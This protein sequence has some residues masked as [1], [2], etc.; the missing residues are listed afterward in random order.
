MDTKKKIEILTQVFKQAAAAAIA[1]DPGTGLE[2][3]GG[4]CN[5]DSPAFRIPGLRQNTIEAA[6]EKAGV[7][8]TDFTWF[9]SQKWFWLGVPLYGQANRRSAMS[10]AASKVLDEKENC[11]PGFESCQYMAMD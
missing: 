10:T 7:T 1:A 6:A 5:L 3:D 11:I 8:I 9:G 4:T 2:N